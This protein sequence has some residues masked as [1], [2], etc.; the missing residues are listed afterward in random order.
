[1]SL[2]DAYFVVK[3]TITV[4]GTN[5]NNRTDKMLA[6]KNNDPFRSCILKINNTFTDNAEDLHIV[7][8]MYNQ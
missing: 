3:G 8:L 1:M 2:S 4:E 6:F 5:A 7:I